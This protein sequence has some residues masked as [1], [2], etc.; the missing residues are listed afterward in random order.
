MASVIPGEMRGAKGTLVKPQILLDDV[1]YD[2][3]DAVVFIGG[4]RC[5]LRRAL[6]ECHPTGIAVIAHRT[7]ATGPL[8]R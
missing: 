3:Y 1:K 8:S 5:P 2:N 7:P 4:V 6:R